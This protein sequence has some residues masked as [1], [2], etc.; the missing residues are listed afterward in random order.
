MNERSRPARRLPDKHSAQDRSGRYGQ[1]AWRRTL[2][3]LDDAEL[4]AVVRGMVA[5]D[6]ALANRRRTA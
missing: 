1:R 2:N 3:R 6:R 5:V 4:L